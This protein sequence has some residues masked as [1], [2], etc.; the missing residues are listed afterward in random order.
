MYGNKTS[1]PKPEYRL[2]VCAIFH[3]HV[4]F[5]NFDLDQRRR[6]VCSCMIVCSAYPIVFVARDFT[7]RLKNRAIQYRN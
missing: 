3:R 6:E 7:W 5:E 4:S 1:F 2:H